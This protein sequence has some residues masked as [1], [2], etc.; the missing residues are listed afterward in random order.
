[1]LR[2]TCT[3]VSSNL[4][5]PWAIFPSVLKPQVTENHLYLCI[6]LRFKH[7]QTYFLHGITNLILTRF[8]CLP[9]TFSKHFF[10]LVSRNGK[11]FTSSPILF[12]H[13]WKSAILHFYLILHRHLNFLTESLLFSADLRLKR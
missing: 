11:L 2:V 1:M 9:L 13:F 3:V 10:L 4:V 5:K 7:F 8:S 6:E 12:T